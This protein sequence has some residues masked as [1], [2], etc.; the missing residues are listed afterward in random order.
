LK[1]SEKPTKHNQEK[2]GDGVNANVYWVT[3]NLLNDW[4]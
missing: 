1:N 4:I 2:R 3:D